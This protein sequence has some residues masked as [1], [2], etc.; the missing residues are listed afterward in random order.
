M[1]L[2]TYKTYLEVFPSGAA[3]AHILE[4]P[5]CFARGASETGALNLLRI[6]VP[7]YFRWL[8]MQDGDT[9]T[10]S[11][12]VEIEV[13]ERVM[14]TSHGL[15]EVLAFFTPD[16]VPLA[17]E[18]LD[19]GLALMSYA[20]IDLMALVQGLSDA[21]LD[22]QPSPLERSIR[23]TIDAVAQNELWLATRL[24][25]TPNV[26]LVTDLAGLAIARYDT[27]HEQAMLRLSGAPPE[28]RQVICEHNG[29][30]WSMRKQIR[31]SIQQEREAT[32]QIAIVVQQQ[33]ART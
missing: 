9:P 7:D 23:Q 29:E 13:A 4:L 16:A 15:H 18:D 27:I 2:A 14:V 8:S 11:G 25:E 21:Q 5:G 6:A 17:D 3:T 24:D 30:R 1:S 22:W 33:I 28:Q 20:H 26:T 19:W 12:E 31:R 32:E 10:M